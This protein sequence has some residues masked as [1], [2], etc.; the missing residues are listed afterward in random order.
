M[1]SILLWHNDELKIYQYSTY[2]ICERYFDGKALTK[3]VQLT[4][5]SWI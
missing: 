3:I 4:I 2:S 5:P 1:K